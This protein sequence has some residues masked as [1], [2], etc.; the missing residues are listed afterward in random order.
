MVFYYPGLSQTSNPAFN[1]AGKPALDGISFLP[2]TLANNVLWLDAADSRTII[3]SSGSVSQWNDKSGS[4]NNVTQGT[5]SEQPTTN[6]TTQN[7]LNVLDFDGGD[8]FI[9]PSGLFSIP[10]GPNTSF[11][12]ARRN[13]E[14]A[15]QEI[16]L[17]MGEVGVNNNH[18]CFFLQTAGAITFFNRTAE[19][20]TV[21]STGNTNTNFQ[22]IRTQRNGTA[23]SI[24]VNRANNANNAFG[25]DAPNTDIG[26]IGSRT[27]G[28]SR[29]IGSIAEMIIYNRALS[30]TEIA[31]VEDY[32][33][34][35]WA[36]T[37]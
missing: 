32:L 31:L 34:N 14:T 23:Q 26:R 36:I 5:G 22:I 1:P 16:I 27:G 3:E 4:G 37:L 29:L 11:Y 10:N 12:V 35:K 7:G 25:Q 2:T 21:N 33:S 19:A 15:A 8:A 13:T 18:M 28:S 30:A 20:N 17:A 9:I 24:E 6:A